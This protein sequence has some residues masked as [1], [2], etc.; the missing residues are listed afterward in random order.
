MSDSKADPETMRALG[1]VKGQLTGIAELIRESNASVNRRLDDLKHSVDA[2]FNDHGQRITKLEEN[3]R[4][5][6][7]KAAAIGATAGAA[8]GIV[9]QILGAIVKFK[10][11]G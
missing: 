8:S 10:I 9:G 3:E 5:T 11:G 1:E 7:I 4:S 6:A 2:R